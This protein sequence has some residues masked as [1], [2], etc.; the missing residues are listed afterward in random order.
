MT[1]FAAYE[2][3]EMTQFTAHEKMEIIQQ[4]GLTEVYRSKSAK[5]WYLRSF[6]CLAFLR[7]T[8]IENFYDE[9]PVMWKIQKIN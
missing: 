6:F 1:Q 5:G 2:K 9:V 4:L 7:P 8:D 3:M